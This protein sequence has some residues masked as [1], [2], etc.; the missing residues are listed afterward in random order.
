MVFEFGNN[1]VD[2]DVERT[3]E[4]YKTAKYITEE[5]QCDGCCNYVAAVE[6]FPKEVKVLFESLGVDIRKSH[7][8]GAYAAVDGGKAAYYAGFYHLCG[9]ILSPGDYEV[10]HQGSHKAEIH[11]EKLYV[12]SK[13]YSI[14][15]T[16]HVALLDAD[17]PSPAIQMEIIFEN[18]PWGL[19]KENSYY[20]T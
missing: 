5:C 9:K 1:T 13:G 19:E 6:C 10:W 8:V 16:N 18:V 12:I 15:F 14:A 3:R 20:R 2:V 17:F 4:Y 11:D 7:E